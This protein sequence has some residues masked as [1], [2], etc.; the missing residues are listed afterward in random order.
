MSGPRPFEK[1]QGRRPACESLTISSLP[2]LTRSRDPKLTHFII[3]TRRAAEI[4]IGYKRVSSRRRIDTYVRSCAHLAVC[5]V[6]DLLHRP[7]GVFRTRL[8]NTFKRF[9]TPDMVSQ[10][11]NICRSVDR[12]PQGR[13]TYLTGILSNSALGIRGFPSSSK[14]GPISNT[15][16]T[17][18]ITRYT[19]RRA[20]YLPGQILPGFTSTVIHNQGRCERHPLTSVRYQK[21]Y[22]QD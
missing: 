21:A 4:V 17:Q 7:Y 3:R 2:S 22:L 10:A 12:W 1:T 6:T 18:A 15:D 13:K 8:D 5:S 16:S 20:R 9:G 11:V 14:T 19:V